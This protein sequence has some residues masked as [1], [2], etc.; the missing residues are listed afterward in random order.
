MRVVLLSPPSNS[1]S[2]L[3]ISLVTTFRS[4]LPRNVGVSDSSGLNV[5]ASLLEASIFFSTFLACTPY[6]F[7][8]IALNEALSKLALA[9]LSAIPISFLVLGL[10]L[11]LVSTLVSTLVLTLDLDSF[12]LKKP[13]TSLS[14][15]SGSTP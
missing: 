14:L 8:V 7:S 6:I 1:F 5:V 2:E 15:I 12:P 9:G 11:A 10:V 13:K 3:F 4:F